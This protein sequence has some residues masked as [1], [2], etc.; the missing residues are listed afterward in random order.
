MGL[1][2]DMNNALW[3]HDMA[4]FKVQSLNDQVI[5]IRRADQG[6]LEDLVCCH[7]GENRIITPWA[8]HYFFITYLGQYELKTTS[9]NEVLMTID[10]REQYV[11]FE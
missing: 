1:R 6:T 4:M 9:D 10:K 2:C 11:T 7:T 5:V 3:C 8:N